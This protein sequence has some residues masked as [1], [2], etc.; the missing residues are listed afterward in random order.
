M[1]GELTREEA[2]ARA[3]SA[4]AVIPVGAC[5]QHGPHLP[6]GTD[7][8]VVEHLA[9]RVADE[10]R[11]GLDVI[12]TPSVVVGY[13]PHHVGIGTTLTH[14]IPT[15]LGVLGELC[16]SLAEAGFTRVFLLNGHGGN[17]EIVPVAARA[18]ARAHGIRVGAG[19]YWIM[20]WNALEAM[21]AQRHG[22]VPGHSGAF[23]TSLV[24]AIRPDLVAEPP[25]NPQPFT[26]NPPGYH[27]AFFVEDARGPDGGAGYSDDPSRGSAELGVAF[28]DTIVAAVGTKLTEFAGGR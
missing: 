24:S 20:A 4:L 10:D 18:A 5:E 9:H 3:S 26:P 15:L 8:L 13:S 21:D 16:G 11:T 17:A 23:E 27:G 19:S 22:R 12:V 7:T 6:L 1:L 28:L 25:R 2:R 14:G